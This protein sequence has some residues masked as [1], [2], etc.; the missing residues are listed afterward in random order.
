MRARGTGG[1]VVVEIAR[2]TARALVGVW[3]QKV[4]S[5]SGTRTVMD[6]SSDRVDKTLAYQV[7]G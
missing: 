7:V 4:R 6:T 1:A 5:T 3:R 2:E